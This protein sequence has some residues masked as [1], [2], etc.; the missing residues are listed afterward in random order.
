MLD[1]NA[2]DGALDLVLQQ[3]QD[4]MLKVIAYA[5]RAL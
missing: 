1:S 4:G 5:R 3:E 2:S